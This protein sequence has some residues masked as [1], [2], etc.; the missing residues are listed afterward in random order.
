VKTLEQWLPSCTSTWRYQNVETGMRYDYL[1]W[2]DGQPPTPFGCRWC[3][4]EQGHHGRQYLRG[5]KFHVWEQPT[6]VQI[7]ARMRARRNAWKAV[8]RCVLPELQYPLAPVVDPW[9]CEAD[10]CVMHDRLL[11]SWLTPLSF[12]QADA[13][14]AGGAA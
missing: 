2:P 3:G 7:L 1:R 6:E 10:N 11:G 9:Q 5:R 14:F 8:C 13:L 4:D 12:T